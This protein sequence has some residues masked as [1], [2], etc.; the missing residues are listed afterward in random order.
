M[1]IVYSNPWFC[2][3][4][5]GKYHYIE[6]PQSKNSAAVLVM[7]QNGSFVFVEVFRHPLG[8]TM[9]EIPRGYAEPGED[10]FR[11]AMREVLEETGYQVLHDDM[12]RIGFLTPNS[13]ILSSCVDVYL[14]KVGDS[15]RVSL[16]DKEVK[17]VV[18]LSEQE[19]KVC[20][21]DGVITDAFTL[22]AFSLYQLRK[23]RQ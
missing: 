18:F 8:K 21:L 23:E 19:L 10:S 12:N 3:I 4:Q 6:E 2:V 13:G 11:C 17:R 16:P 7:H 14:G 5:D 9:L 1:N 22:G 20:I 15:E